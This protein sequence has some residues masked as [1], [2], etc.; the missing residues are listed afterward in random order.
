LTVDPGKRAT[1]YE[2]RQQFWRSRRDIAI[3]LHGLFVREAL[4][5]DHGTWMVRSATAEPDVVRVEIQPGGKPADAVLRDHLARRHAFDR[6][7]EHGG[8]LPVNPDVLLPVTRTIN[9]R[10]ALRS[11]EA[12][13]VEIEDFATGWV[14]RGL[15]KDIPAAVRRAWHLAWSRS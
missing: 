4:A 1:T 5:H 6:V 15:V 13:H 3:A 10:A 12:Y 2:Q 9:Y 11:G 14:D 8:E 7:L